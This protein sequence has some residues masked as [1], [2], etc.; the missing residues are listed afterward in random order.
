MLL[1]SGVHDFYIGNKALEDLQQ[2]QNPKFKMIA[3]WTGR[4]NL[5]LGLIIA[6]FRSFFV[7]ELGLITYPKLL[8]F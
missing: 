4:L 3:R 7:S 2:N 1:I 8:E 5:L 6:F